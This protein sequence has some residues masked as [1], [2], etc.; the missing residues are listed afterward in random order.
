M[1]GASTVALAVFGAVG[2][3]LG[4]ASTIRGSIRVVIGGVLA[5]L[6][7]DHCRQ[8]IADGALPWC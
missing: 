7:S 3:A 5:M 6:V 2:A 1:L 8:H 4:G